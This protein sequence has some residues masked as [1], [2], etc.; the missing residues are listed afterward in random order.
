MKVLLLND[1]P[2]VDR[3]VTLSAEK[4]QDD[5]VKV[6]GHDALEAGYY[7][8]LIVEES[9]AASHLPEAI[10]D[11]VKYGYILFIASR[12]AAV[13]DIYDATLSKPFLP[14]EL[15][16]VFQKADDLAELSWE[17]EVNLDLP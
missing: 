4:R 15:L 17:K 11:N 5:L 3:L 10:G 2:V 8:F 6:S 14:T 12:A 7:D 16:G 9:S 1:N 13:P